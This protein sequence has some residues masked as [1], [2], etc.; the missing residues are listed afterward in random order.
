MKVLGNLKMEL[1]KYMD[2]YMKI[3]DIKW[4]KSIG[5]LVINYFV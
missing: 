3:K 5:E 2:N 4:S 1:H